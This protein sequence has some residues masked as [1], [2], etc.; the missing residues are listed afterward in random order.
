MTR[1]ANSM[2]FTTYSSMVRDAR[3]GAEPFPIELSSS[4]QVLPD[5]D[6]T[7]ELAERIETQKVRVKP[8]WFPDEL[9]EASAA[10]QCAIL[11]VT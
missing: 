11:H 3:F 2:T 7:V 6:Q 9:S 1:K 8:L 10:N 4:F 5:L